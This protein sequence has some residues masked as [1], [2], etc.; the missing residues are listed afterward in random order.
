M[1]TVRLSVVNIKVNTTNPDATS[2]ILSDV[3]THECQGR[4]LAA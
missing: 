2:R 4:V 1:P 3:A